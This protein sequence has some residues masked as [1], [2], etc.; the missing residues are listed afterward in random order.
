MADPEI[1][2]L[3]AKELVDVLVNFTANIDIQILPGNKIIE[4]RNAG[5]NKGDASQH[6]LTKGGYDFIMAL[7]D[8]L[9]DEDLF[10]S[11]PES[12]Y[13]L[14]VGSDKSLARFIIK[15]S[16]DAL[17]LLEEMLA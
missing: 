10:K 6:W 14:K 11:M 7:G 5:I 3:K 8:D 15:D 9:T 1:A 13:S 17:D 12:A 2:S 16:N 4:V